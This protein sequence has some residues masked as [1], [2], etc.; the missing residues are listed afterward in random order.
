MLT[1]NELILK[2]IFTAK[3]NAVLALQDLSENTANFTSSA[4][5]TGNLNAH[6]LINSTANQWEAI[7]AGLQ[8]FWSDAFENISAALSN[9]QSSLQ[10]NSDSFIKK[11]I[12]IQASLTQREEF[13]NITSFCVFQA[14]KETLADVYS[15]I[16]L[17]NALSVANITLIN[18]HNTA[19]GVGNTISDGVTGVGNTISDGF[20]A[21]I[22]ISM[23]PKYYFKVL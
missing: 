3:R 15:N 2:A 19:T 4:W 14:S 8:S 18:V 7:N 22:T 21:T 5:N 11:D 23:N 6:L 9:A 10:V 17:A 12:K 20:G 13:I 16:T 1:K